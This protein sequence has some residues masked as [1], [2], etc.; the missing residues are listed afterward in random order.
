MEPRGGVGGVGGGGEGGGYTYIFNLLRRSSVLELEK[1]DVDDGHFF[2][3]LFMC[4]WMM[5]C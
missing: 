1:Y 2:G 3:I 4:G 5:N